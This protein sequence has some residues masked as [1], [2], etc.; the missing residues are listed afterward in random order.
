M[1]TLNEYR[2]MV[3]DLAIAYVLK[4]FRCSPDQ[5][6]LQELIGCYYDTVTFL[7]DH[8]DELESGYRGEDGELLV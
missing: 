7:V 3:H 4:K 1:T 8:L 6:D 2:K 5:D